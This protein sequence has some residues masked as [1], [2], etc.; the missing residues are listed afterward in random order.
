MAGCTP[1]LAA[2]H[3]ELFFMRAV[4]SVVGEYGARSRRGAERSHFQAHWAGNILYAKLVPEE[5]A[6]GYG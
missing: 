2:D 6:L 1:R 5:Q 3:Y 4:R